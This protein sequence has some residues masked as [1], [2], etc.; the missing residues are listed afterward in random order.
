MIPKVQ[1]AIVLFSAGEVKP[2]RSVAPVVATHTRNPPRIF[3]SQSL[4][5]TRLVKENIRHG[6]WRT[7]FARKRA[8]LFHCGNTLLDGLADA[9]KLIS[10]LLNMVKRSPTLSVK[11]IQMMLDL[12]M[13][14][15]P[16]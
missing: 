16:G 12:V 15:S 8:G 4:K 14:I 3:K 2:L 7:C 5:A 6:I 10:S 13:S 11:L 1:P 9:S